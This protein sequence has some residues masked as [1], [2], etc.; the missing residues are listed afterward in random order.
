MALLS[1]YPKMVYL[2]GSIVPSEDAKISVFDRGF[3]LGDGVYEVMTYNKGNF[4]KADY[5]FKRLTR[6]L[7]EL[8]IH[9]NPDSLLNEIPKVLNASD[10][11][12]KDGLLY[13]QITRGIAPRQHAFPEK[14]IPSVLMYAWEKSLPE[15]NTAL[16][17][18]QIQEEFRWSRCDIKST[19]LLGNVLANQYAASRGCYETLFYREGIITEASHCNVFFVKDETVFTHPANNFILNGITRQV[20]LELCEQEGIPVIESG[21]T[22]NDI[23]TMDE[24]FLTGTSTQVMAISHIENSMLGPGVIGPITRKIQEALRREKVKTASSTKS[25]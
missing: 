16:A 1:S 12:N 10:L 18:V 9:F 5:H 7:T 17:K 13:I 24:A 19:S 21:V 8:G 25:I 11:E 15:I 23:Q 3:L 6:S 20:V 14:I 4:F 22:L 2:N